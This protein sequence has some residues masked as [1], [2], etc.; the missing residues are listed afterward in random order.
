MPTRLGRH[1]TALVADPAA[2]WR[3]DLA[4]GRWREAEEPL[5]EGCPCPACTR[6]LSRAYLSYLARS[7]EL[8]AM[9]LLTAHNLAF[10]ARLMADLRAALDAGRLSEVVAALRAGAEPGAADRVFRTK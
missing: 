4:K 7:G 1:G 10:L 5:L 3:L 2:R 8:T 6:G 9:R